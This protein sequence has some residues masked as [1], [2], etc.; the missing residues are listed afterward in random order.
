MMSASCGT[1]IASMRA[2][3]GEK[4]VGRQRNADGRLF[5]FIYMMI[6]GKAIICMYVAQLCYVLITF[7]CSFVRTSE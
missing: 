3:V 7:V 2:A 6:V 5:S 1:E 4:I